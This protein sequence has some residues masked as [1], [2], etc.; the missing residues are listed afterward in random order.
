MT[1]IT[2][3][4]GL[5]LASGAA[6]QLISP[7]GL[8]TLEGNSAN[9]YPF[10]GTMHYMQIHGDVRGAATTI[11]GQSHRRGMSDARQVARTLEVEIWMGE[12]DFAAASATFA[13]NYQTPRTQVFT[14]KNVSAP[15]W[16]TFAGSPPPFDL[17]FAYDVPFAYSGTRDLVWEM[18]VTQNSANQQT[19]STD[20]HQQYNDCGPERTLGVGC[21]ATGQTQPMTLVGS[22]CSNARTGRVG[23]SWYLFNGAPSAP[24]V[25][26]IGLVNP[27]L[28][29]PG[30]CAPTLYTDAAVTVST[31][32][33]RGGSM[34]VPL[35]EVAFYPRLAG[36]KTY[37]QAATLDAAQPGLPLAVSNGMEV[38]VIAPPTIGRYARI[39]GALGGASGGL[40]PGYALVTRFNP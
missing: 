20:A 31:S 7:A 2:L 14:R 35:V 1:R 32:T 21:Q 16:T 40:E 5:A 17:T 8:A 36:L 22:H 38:T 34:D 27:A 4:A 28:P 3:A 13:N 39:H 6:A 11:R 15:S 37:T 24:G 33:D 30:M 23:L 26:L 10:Y 19:Y 18:A 12:G 25:F 29:L 9:N